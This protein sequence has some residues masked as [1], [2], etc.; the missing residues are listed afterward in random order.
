MARLQGLSPADARRFRTGRPSLDFAHTG[1]DGPLAMWELLVDADAVAH[2]LGVVLDVDAVRADR[3]RT[4]DVFALR[5][6]I[7]AAAHQVIAGHRIGGAARHVINDAARLPPVGLELA[8][9]G[10]ARIVDPVTVEH[11]MST[12]ARDAVDLFGGPF[13]R[14]IREC[15]APDCGLLFVDQ[16]RPGT[17][18][19]C[20][21]QRCGTLTKVRKHRR[22]AKPADAHP[23]RVT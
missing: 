19:W 12:L 21:M 7:W 4:D 11:A 13:A 14:R 15:A 5:R 9:D 16:S 20:S 17:R 1:G 18:R 23:S 8:S 22:F 2:W 6:G 10:N 3:R